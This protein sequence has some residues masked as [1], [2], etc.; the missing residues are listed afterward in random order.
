MPVEMPSVKNPAQADAL[1]AQVKRGGRP[2]LF[3]ITDPMRQPLYP[4]LLALHVNPS[5][6]SEN[7]Q[8]SKNQVMTVG[9]YVEFNWPDE[10]DTLSA[11][12]STGAFLGPG[13]GLT[14]G[15]DDTAGSQGQPSFARGGKGRH[16]TMA[17]ERQ[18]DLLE[19]FHNN[20]VI[21]DGNGLPALRG[22][23]MAI[24]DRGIYF[25]H[26][27]RF[28]VKETDEKAFAFDLSWE[29][30]VEE[31]LYTFPG[32]T[33]RVV[34]PSQR[35]VA[36]SPSPSQSEADLLSGSGDFAQNGPAVAPSPQTADDVINAALFPGVGGGG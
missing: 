19:L 36:P 6:L 12:S 7:F 29:F 15:S 4:Y 3:Q 31:S 14:A 30:A 8:K 23:V 2:F 5:E 27:T 33:S 13:V 34:F 18:Q 10:L 28:E 16:A 25:G 26:F 11:Q 32:S 35:G 17:W 21:Y 9:G 1:T 24:Y 22:R 20:G